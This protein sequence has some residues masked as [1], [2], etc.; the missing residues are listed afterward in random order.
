MHPVDL[1]KE[2][3]HRSITQA[4]FDI[5]RT[6]EGLGPTGQES[7]GHGKAYTLVARSMPG[8]A[9]DSS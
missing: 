9:I 3:V 2:G 1:D 5:E 7:Y 6:Y 4:G 8:S